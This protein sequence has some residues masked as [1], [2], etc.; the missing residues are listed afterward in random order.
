MTKEQ[1]KEYMDG[2]GN[3]CP[4]CKSLN[5][6]GSTDREFYGETQDHMIECLD[7]EKQWRD[8]YKLVDVEEQK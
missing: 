4:F 3:A 7:C 2:G 5:I 6:E 8:I 1:K